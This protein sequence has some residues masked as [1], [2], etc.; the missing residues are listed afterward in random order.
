MFDALPKEAPETPSSCNAVAAAAPSG[1]PSWSGLLQFSLVGI[2]LK[3][4]PAVRARDVPSFH[5]LHAD[6]GQRIRYTKHC[7]THGSVDG[8]AIARA[9]EYGPGQH[10][11]VE[12]EELDQ[13][14]PAADRALR[15]ERFLE[16]SQFE[17]LLYSGRGLYLVPDG[18][19]AETAYEVLRTALA[20]RGRWAVGQM[21]LGGH[22]QLVLVRPA[23]TVLLLHVLHYP[24]QARACPRAA[25]V[26]GPSA[27]EELRL[28]GMLIDAASG[29]V[30]WASYRDATA[31]DLRSLVEAKLQGRTAASNEE[32]RA[33]LPL[34][35]A[36]R[37]SVA[38]PD[39]KRAAFPR[40]KG[41][42]LRKRRRKTA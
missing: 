26:R 21:V 25:G 34:L 36:L 39:A 16:P 38:G 20:E 10:V 7:P 31:E 35:E 32:Q 8:A 5:Q 42:A 14:R 3:A 13:L 9:Y 4:Y 29:P 27:S 6:C 12:P 24:E 30:D 17:P 40:R 33:V 41:P 28:A 23:G 2:P 18:L 15:L 1:R 22:R 19:A 11:V 37:R